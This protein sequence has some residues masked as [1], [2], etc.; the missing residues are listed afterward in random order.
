[1]IDSL[2]VEKGYASASD[3]AERMGVSKPTVTSIVKKLHREGYL[4]HTPYRGIALTD[5][6]RAL[7]RS[8]KNRHEILRRLLIVIGVSVD[9]ASEDAERI[10]HGL[11]P[12]TVRK[13][14]RLLAYLEETKWKPES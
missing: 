1:M 3:I 2:V 5:S 12:D 11:H 10:E 13:F 4:V 14:K 7:A 6:G 9:V 8:M